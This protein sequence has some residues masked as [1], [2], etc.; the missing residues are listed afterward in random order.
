MQT[1]AIITNEKP[2]YLPTYDTC[3]VCGQAHP[4]GLRIRFFVGEFGQVHAWSS[5]DATQTG[6]EN[7]VHGGVVSALLDELL[8]WPIVLQTGR[9]AYTAELTVRFVKPVRVGCTY[10]ATAHPGTDRGRYWEGSGDIRGEDGKVYVKGHGKYFL[11]SSAQTRT[12]VDG[13][14]YQ[15]GDPPVLRYVNPGGNEIPKSAEPVLFVHR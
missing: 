13:L 11:L 9:M 2:T 4:C 14:T 15:P 8:G 1:N 3:F 12:V 6:Y 10:L 7:I 5:P